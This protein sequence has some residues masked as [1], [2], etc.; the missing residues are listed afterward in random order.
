MGI[1]PAPGNTLGRADGLGRA[2]RYTLPRSPNPYVQQ[3]NL[4]L[5]RVLGRNLVVDLAYVGMRGEHLPAAS[6]NLNQLPDSDIVYAIRT[7]RSMASRARSAFFSAQVPNPFFGVITNA[8]SAL[9]NATVTRAQLLSPYPKYT[10]V[11]LYR[12]NIGRGKL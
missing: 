12:P 11:T 10:R 2:S 6:L 4:V 1:P 7:T 3:W 9:R 8:A 5:E